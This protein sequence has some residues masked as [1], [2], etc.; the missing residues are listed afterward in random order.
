M[1]L[2]IAC[3]LIYHMDLSGW[4]YAVAAGIWT[5]RWFLFDKALKSNVQAIV[6]MVRQV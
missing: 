4:W 1:T 5:V 3:L 6:T 2:L